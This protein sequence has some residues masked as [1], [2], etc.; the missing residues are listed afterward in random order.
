VVYPSLP[1]I[2]PL[3]SDIE[4]WP[5]LPTSLNST[6]ANISRR[7]VPIAERLSDSPARPGRAAQFQSIFNSGNLAAADRTLD[8]VAPLRESDAETEPCERGAH[9]EH[10]LSSECKSN[11][12]SASTS[13]SED[14]ITGHKVPKGAETSLEAKQ[15]A[16]TRQRNDTLTASPSP[17]PIRSKGNEDNSKLPLSNTKAQL[18]DSR[19]PVVGTPMISR[20][21]SAEPS[22]KEWTPSSNTSASPDEQSVRL[23]QAIAA[24][25]SPTPTCHERRR[26]LNLNAH[27]RPNLTANPD[28]FRSVS[29]DDWTDDEIF[30]PTRTI[31]ASGARVN[32]SPST[33][34]IPQT[35]NRS[36][37]RS[38][39]N[40][41]P[42]ARVP[43]TPQRRASRFHT[44]RSG[45]THYF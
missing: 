40:G 35:P 13:S 22:S 44:P 41:I 6:P 12:R 19:E 4:Q 21:S 36:I 42:G 17:T 33:S 16:A 8:N 11:D 10:G 18:M 24:S 1:D 38:V 31:G 43:A 34:R 32:A 28:R 3:P 39:S 9:N 14:T 20:S 26:A 37:L 30:F 27:L 15:K 7:R 2:P 23:E 25:L 29:S 5:P 45:C